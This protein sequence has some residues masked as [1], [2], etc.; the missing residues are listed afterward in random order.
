VTLRADADDAHPAILPRERLRDGRMLT[1][2]WAA[3]VGAP[4]NRRRRAAVIVAKEHPPG[5]CATF[6]IGIATDA[7]FGPVITFGTAGTGRAPM[8]P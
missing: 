6:A 5:A 4:A 8:S 3:I 7:V 1:R 2:A